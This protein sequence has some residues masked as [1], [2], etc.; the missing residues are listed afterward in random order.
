MIVPRLELLL[1]DFDGVLARYERSRRCANLAAG[2]GCAPSRVMEV[3]FA[4][5]LETAYDGGA[6]TTADY[7]RRLGDGL[8]ARIGED[9]WIAARVAACQADPRILAMVAAVAMQC[10][11]AVLTNNGPL[12]ARAIERIVP[13][14]ARSLDGRV[15]CSGQFGGRKP[16]REVYLRALDALGAQPRHTLFID[17]LF[18]NVRG[19]RAAGLWADTSRDPRAFRRVLARHRLAG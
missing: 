12:M 7:L 4:S 8:G 16:Q 18:T 9:A 13:G 1:L 6:I 10:P 17:D 2:A 11:V 19:A 14:L 15:F 3:L 5:G